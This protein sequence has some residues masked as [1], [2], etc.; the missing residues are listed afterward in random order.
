M[1]DVVWSAG[2]DAGRLD[3]HVPRGWVSP[4]WN[5]PPVDD[6]IWTRW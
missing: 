6:S 2:Y 4:S 1:E 3:G 5:W